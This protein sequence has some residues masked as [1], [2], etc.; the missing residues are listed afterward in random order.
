MRLPRKQTLHLTES[1]RHR[2]GRET[3]RSRPSVAQ[4][5]RQ[6]QMSLIQFFSLHRDPVTRRIVRWGSLFAIVHVIRSTRWQKH[7]NGVQYDSPG[8]RPGFAGRQTPSA[9]CAPTGHDCDNNKCRSFGNGFKK[10]GSRVMAM[11]A[12][13]RIGNLSFFPRDRCRPLGASAL[14]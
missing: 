12:K 11:Q 5:L 10:L 6:R 2:D 7:T 4:C 14:R 3:D 9:P 8:Q 1:Q 13:D